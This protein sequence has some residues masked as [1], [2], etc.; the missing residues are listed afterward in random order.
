MGLEKAK[1]FHKEI[2]KKIDKEIEWQKKIELAGKSVRFRL[3]SEYQERLR[4][5]ED[6]RKKLKLE[7]NTLRAEDLA[8]TE[9]EM[10]EIYGM[11][12]KELLKMFNI[13]NVKELK[14]FIGI[15]EIKEQKI[16]E[17]AADF[18]SRK[19]EQFF[20]QIRKYEKQPWLKQFLVDNGFDTFE[21]FKFLKHIPWIKGVLIKIL[22][23]RPSYAFYFADKYMMMPWAKELAIMALPRTI[24]SAFIYLKDY[25]DQPWASEIIAK[26][27]KK[28]PIYEYGNKILKVVI[29]NENNPKFSKLLKPFKKKIKDV[30]HIG[31][32]MLN[33]QRLKRRE[34]LHDKGY[35]RGGVIGLTNMHMRKLR[36]TLFKDPALKLILKIKPEYFVPKPKPARML[37]QYRVM[38]AR[39]LYFKN[40]PATS[41][42]I[43]KEYK[44]ILTLRQKY[45]K[46]PLFKD[47]NVLCVA[48]N[49]KITDEYYKYYEK[50]LYKTNL[51]GKKASIDAIKK[52]GGKVTLMRAKN[53]L[54]SFKKK[55]KDILRSIEN[56]TKLTVVFD[57]HG[58]RE[59]I[60][61]SGGDIVKGKPSETKDAI[62]ITYQELA[63]AFKQRHMKFPNE[64]PPLIVLWGCYNHT[65][66]RNFYRTL[67]S[68]VTQPIVIGGGEYDMVLHRDERNKYGNEF[69][70]KVLQL[71][72]KGHVTTIGTVMRH[73]EYGSG[74]PSVYIPSGKGKKP[75]QISRK[76][77][78][79]LPSA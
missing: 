33:Q 60:Y 57:G 32:T 73:E 48:N 29:E 74:N 12:P 56:T 1:K 37:V 78:K 49:E 18:H 35:S 62:K 65:F 40:L 8:I 70:E 23:K 17:K 24:K 51:F 14:E 75:V 63:K 66:L 69:F 54:A 19:S 6:L 68:R 10:E 44:S 21:H 36:K 55:K 2:H 25:A 58:S 26:A 42:N 50:H 20:K 59:G 41:S 13:N 11:I 64:K 46:I 16:Y 45:A 71:S 27:I 7:F 67:G 39:N 4:K 31:N 43:L 61:L 30:M 52:Q 72:K 34:I 15:S 22:K 38:V 5:T 9:Q 3:K 76:D 77:L 28:L 79:K 47:R 53:N